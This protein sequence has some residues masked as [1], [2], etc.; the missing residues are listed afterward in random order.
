LFD[1]K[2]NK[3]ITDGP[4]NLFNFIRKTLC[5]PN[6]NVTDKAIAVIQRNAFYAYPENVLLAMLANKDSNLKVQISQ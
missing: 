1:I 4:R 6:K 5:F 2:Q 3:R